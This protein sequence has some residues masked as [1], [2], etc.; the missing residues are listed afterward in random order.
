MVQTLQPNIDY[1]VVDNFF[2]KEYFQE[3]QDAVI[4][5]VNGKLPWA[6]VGNLNSNHVEQDNECYFEHLAYFQEPCSGLYDILRDLWQLFEIKSL[7]RIK[8]NCYPSKENLVLHAP[9]KDAPFDH[10]GAL[11]YLNTCDGYTQLIDG[12]KIESVENRVLFFNAGIEHSSTNCTNAKAR[13][14]INVNYF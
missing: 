4:N 3:L 6:F 9:H 7:M 11:I 8:A 14:N 13:F 12:T 2:E 1:S 10:K 5:N